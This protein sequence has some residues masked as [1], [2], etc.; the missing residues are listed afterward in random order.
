MNELLYFWE[1][2]SGGTQTILILLAIFIYFLPTIIQ[3]TY[4]DFSLGTFTINLFFWWTPLPYLLV[5]LNISEHNQGTKQILKNQ[6]EIIEI[7]RRNKL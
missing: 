2:A 4:T 6:A 3:R 1:W 5:I 7:L